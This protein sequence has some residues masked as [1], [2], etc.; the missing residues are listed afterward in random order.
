MAIRGTPTFDFYAP[1]GTRV[2]RYVGGL[3]DPAD[4]LLLGK[5]IASGAYRDRSFEDYR[6][7]AGKGS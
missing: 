6:R 1:D 3:F 7:N 5:F 2:Y 4:F